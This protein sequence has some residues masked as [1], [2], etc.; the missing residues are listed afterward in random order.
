MRTIKKI[1]IHCTDSDDS[2]DIG[3]RE[4]N[5]W[6]KERGWLSASGIS[7]GYHYIIRRTGV[8]ERGRPDADRGAH[9]AGHNAESI[10]IT[11]VGRRELSQKQYES[12]MALIRGL[13]HQYT[14]DITHVVGHYELDSKKTCPNLNMDKLRANLLFPGGDHDGANR[15]GVLK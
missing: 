10:G 1:V 5:Q 2:L 12:M 9:V 14:V 13:M 3:F 15:L 11:W 6:H 4:I 8:V 7:C